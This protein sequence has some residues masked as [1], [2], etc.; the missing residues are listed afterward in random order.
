MELNRYHYF[1]AGIVVLLLGIQL[2]LVD[3][4]VL[5]EDTTKWLMNQSN[6]PSVQMAKAAHDLMPAAG[7][8]PRKTIVP[9]QWIGWAALSVGSVLVLHALALPK[10]AG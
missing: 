5:N 8:S 2:R 10:P 6:D 1:V 3:S 4:Y 9:P 7:P